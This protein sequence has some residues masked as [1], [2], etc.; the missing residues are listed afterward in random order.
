WAQNDAISCNRVD[1]IHHVIKHG[2]RFVAV[3][4]PAPIARTSLLELVSA[5]DAYVTSASGRMAGRAPTLY[6]CAAFEREM[7]R[8]LAKYTGTMAEYDVVLHEMW[9][10]RAFRHNLVEVVGPMLLRLDAD[11]LQRR[12]PHVQIALL[13]MEPAGLRAQWRASFTRRV[14]PARGVYVA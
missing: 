7:H 13:D 1:G 11:A 4:T 8:V 12:F 5:F 9:G 10:H 14:G 2:V 6:A 3:A